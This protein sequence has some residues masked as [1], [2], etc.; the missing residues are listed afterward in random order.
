MS[1]YPLRIYRRWRQRWATIQA[2]PIEWLLCQSCRVKYRGNDIEELSERE[3][4]TRRQELT[5]RTCDRCL[6]SLE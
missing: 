1:D 6:L 2:P 3:I 5:T 4:E